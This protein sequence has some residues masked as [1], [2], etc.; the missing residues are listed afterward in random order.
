MYENKTKKINEIS[1]ISFDSVLY[2]KQKKK[3]L[4]LIK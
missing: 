4:N 2:L 3:K 1:R